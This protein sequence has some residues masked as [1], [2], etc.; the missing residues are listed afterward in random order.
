MPGF[1]VVNVDQI[2]TSYSLEKISLPLSS[3]FDSSDEEDSDLDSDSDSDREYE[4][5]LER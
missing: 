1:S 3:E 5:D 4:R 2:D